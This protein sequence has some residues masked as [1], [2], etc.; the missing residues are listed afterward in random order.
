MGYYTRYTLTAVGQYDEDEIEDSIGEI[1]GY[2]IR[3][4]YATDD[5]KWYN[6]LKDMKALSE[7]FPDVM[8]TL[9]GE[10]E[11]YGDIWKA[12]YK[13]GKTKYVKAEIVFPTISVNDLV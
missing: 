9:S 2:N 13:N 6:C 7:K 8:F 4:D 3:L 1:S 10:G 11:E 5:I 12:M